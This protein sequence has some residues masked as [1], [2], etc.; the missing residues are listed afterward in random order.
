MRQQWYWAACV[1]L[2]Q[3]DESDENS[4]EIEARAASYIE[5]FHKKVSEAS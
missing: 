3:E 4:K 2:L 5:K 1:S